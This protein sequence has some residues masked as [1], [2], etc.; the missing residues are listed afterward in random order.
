[1]YEYGVCV[2]IIIFTFANI[3]YNIVTRV[4]RNRKDN[5]FYKYDI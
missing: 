4:V 2:C 5:N 3:N 1:M